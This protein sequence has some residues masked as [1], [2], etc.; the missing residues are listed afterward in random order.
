MMI[1]N[2]NIVKYC[3]SS[4]FITLLFGFLITMIYIIRSTIKVPK[5]IFTWI[6]NLCVF[7]LFTFLSV[8]LILGLVSSSP[9]EFTDI[10]DVD[11][12]IKEELSSVFSLY[13]SKYAMYPVVVVEMIIYVTLNTHLLWGWYTEAK[14]GT[15]VNK[16][17]FTTRIV[18][19]FNTLGWVVDYGIRLYGPPSFSFISA[20]NYCAC[21][22]IYYKT[23]FYLTMALNFVNAFVRFLCVE[24]PIEY[25]NR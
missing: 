24:Y 22:I 25:H 23:L 3:I 5:G 2:M 4:F 11:I 9:R 13:I 20:D 10:D 18:G 15:N 8:C 14:L 21:W 19:I 6:T 12:M 1:E 17:I 16:V 7:T